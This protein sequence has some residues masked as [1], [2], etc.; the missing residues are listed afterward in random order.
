MPRNLTSGQITALTAEVLR[1]A[2]FVQASFISTTVYLWTGSGN[3]TWNG[4][5][6]IGLG[7]LLDVSVSEDGATVSPRGIIITLSGLDTTLLSEAL[8]DF[9]LGL[10]VTV[11][12]ALYDSSFALIDAPFI[13]WAGRMDQPDFEVSGT[14]CILTINCEDRLIDLNTSVSRR[15]TNEDLQRDTPGD[16]GCSFVDSIQQITLN[17]GAFPING[18]NI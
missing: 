4:H 2:V 14:S 6:W 7:S 1:T 5:T 10:P 9:G 8:G 12:L 11:Y 13:T 17:W 15:Y 18:N 3:T 16:L